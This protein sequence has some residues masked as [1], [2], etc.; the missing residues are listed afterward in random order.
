MTERT[1]IVTSLRRAAAMMLHY[2]RKDYEGV[3]TVFE[4]TPREQV[5]DLIMGLLTLQGNLSAAFHPEDY[6][7]YLTGIVNETSYIES[8]ST[9]NEA[10]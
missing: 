7:K 3:L 9:G 8:S 4:D 2:T 10:A 1:V 5:H 6:M